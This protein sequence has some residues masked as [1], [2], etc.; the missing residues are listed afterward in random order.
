MVD[1]LDALKRSFLFSYCNPQSISKISRITHLKSY[2]KND[3]VFQEGDPALGF[4]LVAS[5]RVKVYK[6]SFS[7]DE[8]ILHVVSEG[9]S[10][11]EAVVFSPMDR[12]PAFAEALSE[13][14]LLFIPKREFL[15]LMRNDF[16]LTLSVFS[17][18]SEKLRS[19]NTLVE[20]LSLK[21]AD[22]R[23]AKYL[24][25]LAM[26]KKSDMFSLDIKKVELSKRLGIAPETLSRL[27]RR[28]K[29]RRILAMSGHE[30]RLLNKESLRLISSGEKA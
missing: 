15:D 3:V 17:S 28:F 5:G 19:F 16:T 7:G 6:L 27:L 23:L 30:I 9:G 22:S 18:M 1:R 14:R 8:H 26:K 12:Y 20:E 11:A 21:S 10:F 4:Y 13:A 24:L 29:S 25:D 2:Q